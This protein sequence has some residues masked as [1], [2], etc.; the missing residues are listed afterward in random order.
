MKKLSAVLILLAMVF[1]LVACVADN[2]V[3]ETT[4]VGASSAAPSA[5]FGT[6]TVGQ[7]P[8]VTVYGNGVSP[9]IIASIAI[10]SSAADNVMNIRGTL[11]TRIGKI[12]TYASD[13]REKA[14]CEMVFGETN[15]AITER[16]K[17]YLPALAGDEIG[18]AHV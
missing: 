8:V 9:V 7:G 3:E 16:A 18:R 13:A 12:P 10:P 17:E 14:E 6:E 1:Q 4:G 11:W 15:R 5:S 2:A